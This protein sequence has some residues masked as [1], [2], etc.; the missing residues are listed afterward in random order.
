MSTGR[1]LR[2]VTHWT[3]G[4]WTA[5]AV[6]RA[7]YHHLTEGDGTYVKGKEEPEDNIVTADGDYARH[8]LGLNT[9]S[10][11]VAMC[12]MHG[13]SEGPPIDFGPFPITERQFERHCAMLADLHIEYAIPV[14]PKTCL[15][16]AEV[17]A[18][19][20]VKQKGKWDIVGLEF[21]PE[22]RGA[23]AVGDY[24]RERVRFYL[25]EKV[26]TGTDVQ[27]ITEGPTLR[28]GAQGGKVEDL[29]RQLTWLGYP[30]G[31]I[32][33]IKGSRTRA[34]VM[35]FQADNGLLVDGVVGPQTW[36]ALYASEKRP[37]RDVTPEQIEDTSR[38]VAVARKIKKGMTATDLVTSATVGLGGIVELNS[39]AA[40]AEGALETGQRLLIEYWPILLFA[41]VVVIATRYGRHLA[42]L[43]V[44]YRVED[45]QSGRHIGP[46][47][48][49]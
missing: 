12:A 30:V 49:G 47:G 14:T 5:N 16:H 15:T 26:G 3:G 21:K 24:M 42:D 7:A 45:G 23:I 46:G 17:E 31:N 39:A 22:L 38:T 28:I 18:V 4:G 20:G 27:P 8:V 25:A 48:G 34:A 32:D 13:S 41:L 1:L 10:I 44:R 11:G 6:D 36:A 2:T 35:A 19:L 40:Q 29:Q 33:G 37:M 43:I 9:G